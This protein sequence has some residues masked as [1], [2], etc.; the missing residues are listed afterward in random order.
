MDSRGLLILSE[1][2]VVAKA[3]IGPASE[4]EKEYKV[5]VTGPITGT[6]LACCAMALRSTAAS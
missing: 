4:L 2:G 5:R 6:R 1:D 3:V